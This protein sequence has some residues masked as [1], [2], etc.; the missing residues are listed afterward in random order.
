M[1][2]SRYILITGATS[3]I[4]KSAAMQLAADGAVVIATSRSKGKG[5]DLLK[6]YRSSFPNGKGRIELV[7][8]D[9]ASFES[10]TMACEEI[11]ESYHHLD[12]LINNAGLMAYKR[13]RSRDK[14]EMTWQVN[15]L[16]PALITHL[17]LPGF[18]TALEPKIIMSTSGFHMGKMDLEDPEFNHKK[19]ISWQ[20]YRQSKLGLIL[21]TRLLAPRFTE[22]GIGIYAQHP[23]L[24][25]TGIDRSG[26]G[27]L[28]L[29]FSGFGMSPEKG[30]QTILYLVNSSNDELISGEYYTKSHVAKSAKGAY[31]MD[32]AEALLDVIKGYLKKYITEASL[33]FP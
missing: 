4:G 10:I 6:D 24:V 21:L 7:E 19:Y 26:P 29:L 15:L 25:K 20:A 30:A 9:L 13:A 8:C 33:I 17:L 14:I 12:V 31:D 27:I 22:D 5:A 11:L 32:E 2:N 3:G 28:K 23:G 16:A 18:K 1:P